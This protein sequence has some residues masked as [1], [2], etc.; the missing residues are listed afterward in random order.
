M[1][2]ALYKKLDTEAASRIATEAEELLHERDLPNGL[3]AR[4]LYAVDEA[5]EF[6]VE[7]G[8]YIDPT[9]RIEVGGL[10]RA[11][12]GPYSHMRQESGILRSYVVARVQMASEVIEKVKE[13]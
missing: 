1:R 4:L 3:S 12:M 7:H 10:V 8:F 2:S 5:L 6:R 13:R 11:I 9:A